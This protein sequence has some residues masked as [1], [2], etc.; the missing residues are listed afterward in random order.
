MFK[1]TTEYPAC[2]LNNFQDVILFI[3]NLIVTLHL[4]HLQI[5]LL[6]YYSS[7]LG[8]QIVLTKVTKLR[9]IQ[10]SSQI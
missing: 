4:A 1:V 5:S 10:N 2:I 9:S 3:H 8:N 7:R 6:L